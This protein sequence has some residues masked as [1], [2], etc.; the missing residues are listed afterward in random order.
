MDEARRLV[1]QSAAAQDSA[2]P[3]G[4][5]V[6]ADRQSAG[7]GRTRGR[8]WV[9]EKGESLLCTLIL[10]YGSFAELP[11]A[12]TLRIGLGVA[13]ALEDRY[14]ALRG[15]VEVK[16]PNDVMIDR[17]KVCGILCE[18]DGK[19]VYAGIGVNIGQRSFGAEVA[20]KAISVYM[21]LGDAADVG[22]GAV[23]GSGGPCES[24]DPRFELLERILRR[25]KD[26]LGEDGAGMENAAAEREAV[27]L[28][29]TGAGAEVTATESWRNALE[30]RL[31]KKGATFDFIAGA[32]DTGRRVRGVLV[33]VGPLGELLIRDEGSG[34][35]EGFHTGE[36][37][38]G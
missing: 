32:A 17:R 26:T 11:A 38:Y 3:H 29:V 21:A 7:R 5:V 6:V 12:L 13:L 1:A 30:A 31:Y 8:V 34:E 27:E 37:P 14:P 36:L 16:W 9:A 10:R 28:A 4:T 25:I 33:G 23:A 19:T 20:E 18:G 15:R 22:V 2:A 24:A 35:V